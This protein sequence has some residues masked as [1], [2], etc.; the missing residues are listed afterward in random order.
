MA[1]FVLQEL[2]D[3]MTDGKKIVYPK[4][5]TYSLHDYETVIKHMRTYAGNISEGLIRAVFDAL[6]STMQSWMPLGHS[7]KIMDWVY[8]PYPWVSIHQPLQRR[9]LPRINRKVKSPRRNTDM[10]A[11]RASTSSQTLSY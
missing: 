1:N 8:S 11:S 6:A 5:Q 4:M 9:L 3:E 10:C 7:I 2:P